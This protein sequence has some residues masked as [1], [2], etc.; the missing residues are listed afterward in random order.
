MSRQ[1]KM[2]PLS[3]IRSKSIGRKVQ[4]AVIM[5]DGTVSCRTGTITSVNFD[6]TVTLNC[7]LKA[8]FDD[9]IFINE[10]NK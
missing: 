6:N 10:E 9:L 1:N 7:G 5:P 4:A 2:S 8:H 3:A